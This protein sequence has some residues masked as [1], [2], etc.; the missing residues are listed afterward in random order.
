MTADP[1]SSSTASAA[2]S[3][4]LSGASAA[5]DEAEL[6][7]EYVYLIDQFVFYGLGR[8]SSHRTAF[9]LANLLFE[10]L[11][12]D[13]V[14]TS[15]APASLRQTQSRALTSILTSGQG[16]SQ[17]Q[18]QSHS[19][20]QSRH[21]SEMLSPSALSAASITSLAGISHPA[22]LAQQHKVWPEFLG[23][24][25]E[26]LHYFVSIFTPTGSLFAQLH[27]FAESLISEEE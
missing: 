14:F 24:W 6:F 22:S 12:R 2:G 18:S 27:D 19:L 9:S 25:I 7:K 8:R 4:L 20:A 23:K 15:F 1:Q 16:Q 17:A 13:P 11:L 5:F 10:T 21:A 26:R 3:S